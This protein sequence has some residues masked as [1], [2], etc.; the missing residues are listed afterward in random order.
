MSASLTPEDLRDDSAR[1]RAPSFQGLTPLQELNG[2]GLALIHRWYLRDLSAVGQLMADIRDGLADPASLAPLVRDMPIAQNLRR[3]GTACGEQCRALTSH[4]QIEDGHLYPQLERHGNNPLNA[5]LIRLRA[6]HGVIHD[7][8]IDLW[9]AA[10]ALADEPGRDR[11]DACAAA[12]VALDRAV[13][14]H[15][16][17]EETEL[18][19]ALGFYDVRV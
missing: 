14:S 3:F 19:P 10:A 12:F 2:R 9:D 13:R 6:E 5:V 1:P 8:I 16:R 11:F 18:A 15:F 7:L 17:Y 4:H